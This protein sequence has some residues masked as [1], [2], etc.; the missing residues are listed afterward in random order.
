MKLLRLQ[1]F[2]YSFGTL[3]CALS[4]SIERYC[5]G[6]NEFDI[7]AFIACDNKILRQYIF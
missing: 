4:F 3:H 7:S 5:E 6:L 1:S 2:L